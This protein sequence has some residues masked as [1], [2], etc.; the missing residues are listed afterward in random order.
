MSYGSFGITSFPP[1]PAGEKS[2]NPPFIKGMNINTIT[3]DFYSQFG[4]N[5]HSIGPLTQTGGIV[6][7]AP[8]SVWRID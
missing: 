4:T 8:G 7:I 6:Q 3:F 1:L 5:Y 2:Q